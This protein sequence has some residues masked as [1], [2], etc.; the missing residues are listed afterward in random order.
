MQQEASSKSMRY[1]CMSYNKYIIMRKKLSD[2]CTKN[3]SDSELRDK[4][5]SFIRLHPDH[6]LKRQVATRDIVTNPSHKEMHSAKIADLLESANQMYEKRE[7][8]KKVRDLEAETRLSTHTVR[9]ADE[10]AKSIEFRKLR[11]EKAREYNLANV[12]LQKQNGEAIRLARIEKKKN[13]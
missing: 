7:A 2:A 9:M 10:K 6:E 4:L 3:N 11:I 8:Y 5:I 12:A 1:L 13:L